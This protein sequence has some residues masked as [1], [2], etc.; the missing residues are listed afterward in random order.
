MEG[1]GVVE[2]WGDRGVTIMNRKF[3]PAEAKMQ[4]GQNRDDGRM[5]I[6]DNQTSAP[7]FM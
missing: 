4:T 6:T 2:G 7:V 3:S 5:T 1:G